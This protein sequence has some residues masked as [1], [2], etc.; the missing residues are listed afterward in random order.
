MGKKT[1]AVLLLGLALGS[2]HAL[3]TAWTM[4]KKAG[5]QS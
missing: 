2:A 4:L 3:A 5:P 1:I